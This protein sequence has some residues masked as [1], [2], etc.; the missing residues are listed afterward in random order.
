MEEHIKAILALLNEKQKRVFLASCANTLGYGGI[1]KVCEISGSSKTTVIKGKKEQSSEE[2][3]NYEQKRS[4]GGGRKKL[5]KE[6]P[7]LPKWI[8]AIVS[9]ETYGNPENPLLWTTKSHRKIQDAILTKH[10]AYVS[11]KS[12]GNQL[13]NL[14]YSSQANKK[15]LQVGEA[16]PD[17]NE[18]FE[19][20]NDMAKFFMFMASL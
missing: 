5:E 2:D 10:E 12:I 13:K 1:K 16:H 20:I 17:R 11:F 18:Q 15:M 3:K 4:P 9:E 7:E 14:G 19:F 6:Y 8:E